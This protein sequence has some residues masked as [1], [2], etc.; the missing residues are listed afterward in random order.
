MEGGQANAR[1]RSRIAV[2]IMSEEAR[3]LTKW[4][5]AACALMSDPSTF[6][7]FTDIVAM[8]RSKF[9]PDGG[10]P[11]RSDFDFLEFRGWWGRISIARIE[12]EP[13]DVRFVLWGTQLTEWWGVDYTQKLMGTHSITPD[14][15]VTIEGRYFK[16][17]V[18]DPFIGIVCGSLDQHLRPY[19]KVLGVDLP[20]SDGAGGIYILTAYVEIKQTDTART[21]LP[22][23][24]FH[25]TI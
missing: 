21:V 15:W 25:R 1:F 12:Q 22:K 18:S 19:I 13:F 11:K 17:M 16:E 3:E 4:D 24:K 5:Y 10:L 9:A 7:P 8:W 2:E 23:T 6:G 20:M 14:V